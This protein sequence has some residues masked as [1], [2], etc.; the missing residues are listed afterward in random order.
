[1][2]VMTR[3]IWKYDFGVK[4]YCMKVMPEGSVIISASM[5]GKD[6]V[7]HA[8]VIDREN[9]RTQYVEFRVYGTGWDIPD[10]IADLWHFAG[11]VSENHG[12]FF[13]HIFY[14]YTTEEVYDKWTK[15]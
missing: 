5:Q 14:N 2:E 7:V 11:V 12:Q 15:K 8:L 10:E 6:I 9:P 3:T 13:W 1:M 4:D